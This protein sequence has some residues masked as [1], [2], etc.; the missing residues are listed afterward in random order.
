MHVVLPE[1]G[2]TVAGGEMNRAVM[3]E[4]E[5][6]EMARWVLGAIDALV[7]GG[8][9]VE[10]AIAREDVE[11]VEFRELGEGIG[12]C[13]RGEGL[14]VGIEFLEEAEAT[15]ALEGFEEG[16]VGWADGE[17]MGV[18]LEESTATGDFMEDTRDEES[19]P[20]G[21]G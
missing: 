11:V 9:G 6:V 12:G 8:S 17:E 18:L 15:G 10:V 13:A 5:A 7:V 3:T 14:E 4:V 2:V 1:S 16:A 20:V 19:E 21:I